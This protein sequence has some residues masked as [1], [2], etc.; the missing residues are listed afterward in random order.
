[1]TI[2]LPSGESR[3]ATYA[4]TF[5][6]VAEGELILFEDANQRLALGVNHG[7]ALVRLGL[8]AGDQLRISAAREAG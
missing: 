2:R 1:M 5:S 8:R 6:E 3:P 7:S 4:V